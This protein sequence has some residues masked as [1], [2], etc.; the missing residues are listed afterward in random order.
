MATDDGS[1]FG[2]TEEQQFLDWL[3]WGE[4][5]VSVIALASQR[6]SLAIAA[7]GFAIAGSNMVEKAPALGYASL[8]AA[9]VF[10]IWIAAVSVM[11]VGA[12][13]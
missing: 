7:G 12:R 4:R 5:F 6:V 11:G 9:S 2:V 8:A 10:G 1:F 3:D 13:R